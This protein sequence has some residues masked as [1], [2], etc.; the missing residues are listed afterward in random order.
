MIERWVLYSVFTLREELR[1][2]VALEALTVSYGRGSNWGGTCLSMQPANV[3][4]DRAADHIEWLLWAMAATVSSQA[5]LG[6][7]YLALTNSEA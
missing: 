3:I 7:G 1:A 5:S 2:K 6:H 4:P